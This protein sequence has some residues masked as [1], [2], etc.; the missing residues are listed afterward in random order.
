MSKPSK[1]RK[2]NHQKLF[3]QLPS[4]TDIAQTAKPARDLPHYFI[5][6]YVF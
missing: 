5:T 2:Q 1:K 4:I 3:L 6:L